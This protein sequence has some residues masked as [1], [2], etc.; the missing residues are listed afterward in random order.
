[1][2][3]NPLENIKNSNSVMYT[4]INGRL[5]DINTMNE[6][7]NY[8]KERGK[9]YFENENYNQGFPVNLKT[10]SFTIPTC[11]CH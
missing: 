4:M 11:S 7:G 6:I 2:D 5:Y 1:M 3:K 10:N 9:F 8:N